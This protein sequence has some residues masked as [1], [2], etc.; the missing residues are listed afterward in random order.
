MWTVA[1]W[2]TIFFYQQGVFHFHDNCSS[3]CICWPRLTVEPLQRF[4]RRSWSWIHC[5]ICWHLLEQLELAP[6][7]AVQWAT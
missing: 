2:I 1:L 3:E 4:G 5:R 7:L 6:A